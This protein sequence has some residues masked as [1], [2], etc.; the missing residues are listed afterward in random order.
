MEQLLKHQIERADP[1]FPVF[2]IEGKSNR[3]VA[4]T[5]I[6]PWGTNPPDRRHLGWVSTYVAEEAR[7]LGLGTLTHQHALEYSSNTSLQFLVSLLAVRNEHMKHICLKAGWAI[8][9]RFPKPL[10][11]PLEADD[12]LISY[13]VP[14]GPR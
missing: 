14:E 9:G 10:K 1:C 8:V 5:S 4:W 7:G 11:P 6:S 2:V 12:Y 3:I 13:P